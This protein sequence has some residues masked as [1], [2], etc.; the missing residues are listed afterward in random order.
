MKHIDRIIRWGGLG[1]VLGLTCA[2]AQDSAPAGAT[3]PFRETGTEY[4]VTSLPSGSLQKPIFKQARELHGPEIWSGV[5]HQFIENTVG[6]KGN[7]VGFETVH[8]D[9]TMPMGRIM[10]IWRSEVMGNGDKLV[11]EGYFI[12]QTDG[13]LLANIWFDPDRCTGRFAGVTGTVTV[14]EAVPPS[15]FY[16]EGTISTV[17]ATKQAE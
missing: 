10:Y 8:A 5:L 3:K 15:G 4:V 7:S 16:M 1:A 14:L 17:G 2:L 9:P 12:P 13:T 11:Q 6:G